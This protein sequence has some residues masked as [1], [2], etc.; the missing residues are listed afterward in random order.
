MRPPLP[1]HAAPFAFP[2]RAA[3]TCTVPAGA[4]GAGI[5]PAAAACPSAES[6]GAPAPPAAAL[7]GAR[8]LGWGLG[9][10]QAERQASGTDAPAAPRQGCS[11]LA[12]LRA[13]IEG[14]RE[15]PAERILRGLGVLH[16]GVPD[17]TLPAPPCRVRPLWGAAGTCGSPK[18]WARLFPT[19]ADE[20]CAGGSAEPG[21]IQTGVSKSSLRRPSCFFFSWG[22]IYSRLRCLAGLPL[23]D[24][25]THPAAQTQSWA[26]FLV[27]GET[28]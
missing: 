20:T 12:A 18:P 1:S 9:W 2:G 4:G 23:P 5:S 10:K 13:R 3:A 27:K 26:L 17:P 25:G 8:R 21:V 28:L 15:Q 19:W 6:N 22:I 14:G 24:P 11:R 16:W 7:P